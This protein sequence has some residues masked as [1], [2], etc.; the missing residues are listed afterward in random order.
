MAGS[1]PRPKEVGLPGA[2]GG[3]AGDFVDLGLVGDRVGGLRRVGRAQQVDLVREDQLARDLGGAVRVRL[4]VLDDD[5]HVEAPAAGIDPAADRLEHGG[6]AELVG[7]GEGRQ[8][9]GSGADIADPHRVRRPHDG[10]EA[11]GHGGAAGDGAAG[12]LQNAAAGVA[13]APRLVAPLRHGLPFLFRTTTAP[14]SSGRRPCEKRKPTIAEPVRPR[15]A[16]SRSERWAGGAAGR[17]RHY[18]APAAP[19]R[20]S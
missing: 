15:D 3:D 11:R 14:S 5:L 10:R 9:P 8:R 4:A 17:R 16:A 12:G 18:A 2:Q 19:G 1:P 6:D 20:E 13:G 7:L